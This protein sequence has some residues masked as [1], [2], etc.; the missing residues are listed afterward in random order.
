MDSFKVLS[1]EIY[2]NIKVSKTNY[3]L[4]FSSMCACKYLKNNKGKI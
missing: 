4:K 1:K 3:I 2:K